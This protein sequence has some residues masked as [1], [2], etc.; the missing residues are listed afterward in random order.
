[1]KTGTKILIFLAIIVVIGAIVVV[2]LKSKDTGQEVEIEIAARKPMLSTVSA[3]GELK[4]KSQVDVQPQLIGLVTK[5]YVKEG[6]LVRQGQVLCQLDR[7]Q[8][9]TAAD[10][11]RISVE[12]LAR[13]FGRNESLYNQHL[14]SQEA[15]EQSKEQYDNAVQQ[16]IQADDLLSKTTI[17]APVSGRVVQLNIQE[18]EMAIAGMTNLSGAVMMTVA[19]LDTMLALVDADETDVPLIARG[20][21]ASLSLDAFPDTTFSAVVTRVGYMPIQTLLTTTE[22]STK[23]EVELQLDQ[24]TDVLRPGMSV[25][26]DITTSQRDSVLSVPIQA[27]GRRKIKGDEVPTLFVVHGGVAKLTV[28]KTGISSD[29]DT[30]ILD[31]ISPGDTVVSGPYKVLSVLKDGAKVHGK[32]D[33]GGGPK[34]D[35]TKGVQVHVEIH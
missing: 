4:A 2:N 22:K 29:T 28:V 20:Q 34:P 23:F 10:M 17:Y 6:D 7:T 1:L 32:T 35:S 5:L 18:G 14:L 11:A 31:G 16:K 30:E 19:D 12:Q 15:Y 27:V 3:T 13:T 26:A 33:T 21:K 24:P 9:Q 25:T 8:Y